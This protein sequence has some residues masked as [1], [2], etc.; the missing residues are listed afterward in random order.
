MIKRP[1]NSVDDLAT[2]GLLSPSD[3]LRAVEAR[4][5]IAVTPQIAAL[6]DPADPNDPIARQF[7]PD[8]RELATSAAELADPIGDE[9]HSPVPGIVHRYR[10]RVLLKLVSVCPVYCRF[11]FRRETVGKSGALSPETLARALDYVAAHEEIGEV[12]LTGGDPLAASA[13]RLLAVSE[14][15]ATIPHV[16]RLRVHTRVPLAAPDLVTTERLEALRLAEKTLIVALHANHARELSQGAKAAIA[17]LK[18]A[19]AKLLSQSVLLNG[20]NDDA[21][22]LDSL[23]DALTG[24][25]V[26]PYYL[27]H[28]DLA[29]GT[30]HFRLSLLRGQKIYAELARRRKGRP[31]PRYVLDLP[32]GFG[33][34]PIEAPY[35]LRV[36]DG[37]WRAR[38]RF[39]VEHRYED[40]AEGPLERASGF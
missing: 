14:R 31:L 7:L 27:H 3:P 21:A 6:I 19:G 23:L 37:S 15:L 5:S 16:T 10:D 4:Y 25:G 33:K 30:A 26:V 39:G 35:L 8:A 11:C 17:R 29:K 2:A 20:V 34:V 22:I 12:I 38:D 24:Q 40:E 1:L 28:P 36:A 18:E 32:G 9:A 13:R